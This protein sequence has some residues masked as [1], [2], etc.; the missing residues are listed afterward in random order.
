[1]LKLFACCIYTIFKNRIAEITYKMYKLD[2]L[3]RNVEKLKYF[4]NFM[5]RMATPRGGGGKLNLAGGKPEIRRGG[6]A[7][8]F[9]GI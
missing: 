9:G 8:D 6:V 1:M 7:A 4:L 2:F 5:F 3:L